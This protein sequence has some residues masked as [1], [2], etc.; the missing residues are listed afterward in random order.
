M[1]VSFVV[2]CYT[3]GVD[4]CLLDLPS[5]SNCGRQKEHQKKRKKE[6]KVD[7]GFI[8]M[9]TATAPDTS[10]Q[11]GRNGRK[12]FRVIFVIIYMLLDFGILFIVCASCV[13]ILFPFIVC[14]PRQPVDLVCLVFGFLYL[15]PFLVLIYLPA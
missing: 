15:F 4:F 7:F 10:T 2:F 12:S 9:C 5:S 1:L 6:K 11:T 13:N 14:A 3:D 8:Q